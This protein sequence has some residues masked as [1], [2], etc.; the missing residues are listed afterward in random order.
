MIICEKDEPRSVA[1]ERRSLGRGG[2]V[3]LPPRK[4]SP[5]ARAILSTPA[6][7]ERLTA[8]DERWYLGRDE[9]A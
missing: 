2:P 5:I 1:A 3:F 4:L 8:Y 9:G 6:E 7:T